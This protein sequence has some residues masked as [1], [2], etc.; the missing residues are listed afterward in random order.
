MSRSVSNGSFPLRNG[1]S[2]S[3]ISA[4][5]AVGVGP[6]MWDTPISPSPVSTF[7]SFADERTGSLNS[8]GFTGMFA[9]ST[10][11]MAVIFN[12]LSARKALQGACS[13]LNDLE[14]FVPHSH[15]FRS[16]FHIHG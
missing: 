8:G 14:D 12:Q 15:V 16:F 13:T 4:A 3:L 10:I 2:S 1:V 7:T 9:R 5:L 6:P 11:S